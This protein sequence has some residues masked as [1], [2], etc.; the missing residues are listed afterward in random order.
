MGETPAVYEIPKTV[1]IAE[2]KSQVSLL[3]DVLKLIMQDG[4]H[5]GKIP[6]AGDKPTLLKAGA[7]KIATVFRLAP[8]P[9]VEDLSFNDVI[10]YRVKCKL[11]NKLTGVTEGSGVGEG[12][13]EEEK[14]KWRSVVSEAEWN[15]TPDTHRRLK[16]YRGGTQIKQ[17]RTNPFDLANTVLKMAKKRALVDA[18]LTVTAA[19]DIFTQ[20]VEDMP[21][22]VLSGN[23]RKQPPI[24]PVK[25]P[26]P[27]NNGESTQ[28]QHNAIHSL[29]GKLNV[30]KEL[31]HGY[32]SEKLSINPPITSMKDLTKTQAS[33]AIKLLS[34][35]ADSAK[36]D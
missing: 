15:A 21:E 6:G 12:S 8:D 11:V 26:E 32:I 10:R 7:E 20:D 22:E 13:T 5:Y 29:L 1:S 14:Y 30:P 27:A 9:E 24:N 17:V 35:I 16:Y 28:P 36:K 25:D 31:H 18:V 33:E 2:I 3:Q 23:G 19:S 34:A 4:T